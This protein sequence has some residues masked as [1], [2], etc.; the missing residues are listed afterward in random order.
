MVLVSQEAIKIYISALLSVQ[1]ARVDRLAEALK[2]P[3]EYVPKL[4]M[5]LTTFR[6]CSEKPMDNGDISSRPVIDLTS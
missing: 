4:D 6:D 3:V 1:Q 5:D 2:E